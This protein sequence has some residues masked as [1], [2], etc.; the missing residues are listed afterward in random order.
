MVS[1]S[2]ATGGKLIPGQVIFFGSI[3]FTA[4]DSAWLPEAPLKGDVLSARGNAHFRADRSGVLI[5]QEPAPY[6]SAGPT[7][8]R[9]RRKRSGKPRAR[10][11]AAQLVG[12]L[13]SDSLHAILESCSDGE[14]SCGSYNSVAEVYMA[15]T[16][17]PAGGGGGAALTA[18]QLAVAAREA[19]LLL[20]TPIPTTS[21]EGIRLEAARLANLAERNRLA[22]LEQDLRAR[23]H[24]V[25][26]TSR[27]QRRLLDRKS[28]V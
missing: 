22:R 5:L 24:G 1:S 26:G 7:P 15:G 12:M 21:P 3:G 9:R 13:N 16:P 19:E 17:P 23:A 4:D 28:V 20:N 10:R 6:R 25:P 2:S 8:V 18:E 27:H 11:P 14:E